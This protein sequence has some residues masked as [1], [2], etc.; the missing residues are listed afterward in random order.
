MS[1]SSLMEINAYQIGFP[2]CFSSSGFLWREGTYGMLCSVPDGRIANVRLSE[3]VWRR[4]AF[5]AVCAYFFIPGD[6][7]VNEDN[8]FHYDLGDCLHL[9][10]RPSFT[11]KKMSLSSYLEIFRGAM[12]AD[13]EIKS[14]LHVVGI[15]H[16]DDWLTFFRCS[17]FD[18]I[19]AC[20]VISSKTIVIPAPIFPEI[21]VSPDLFLNIARVVKHCIEAESSL[22]TLFTAID[23]VIRCDAR[24]YRDVCSILRYTELL[25]NDDEE[26][27]DSDF[28]SACGGIMLSHGN[29]Y[30]RYT[31]ADEL[32]LFYKFAVVYLPMYR[33][34]LDTSPYVI[35]SVHK[36]S[37][38]AKQFFN[39]PL[40]LNKNQCK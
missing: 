30:H 4:I 23:L 11:N 13:I 27:V 25:T 36:D 9:L 31:Y 22:F 20:K 17:S 10:V 39:M 16:L 15:E 28:V 8:L 5:E 24:G 29:A 40:P 35:S 3:D 14:L 33:E 26:E 12:C 1:R 38:N 37:V 6:W 32:L 18:E 7:E 2:F 19:F 21:V 34:P